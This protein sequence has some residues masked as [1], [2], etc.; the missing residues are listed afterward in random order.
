MS[1]SSITMRDI[2]SSATTD[3]GFQLSLCHATPPT[4][5]KITWLCII[6]QADELGHGIP[7]TSATM[8]LH[9]SISLPRLFRIYSTRR[10][11]IA[12]SSTLQAETEQSIPLSCSAT[13]SPSPSKSSSSSSSA[14]LQISAHSDLGSLSVFRL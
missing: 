13:V 8:D 3:T 9:C 11:E 4:I 2:Q 14:P 7:T 6:R 12:R 10:P 5:G 1:A